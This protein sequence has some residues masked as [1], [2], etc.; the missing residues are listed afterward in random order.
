MIQET[1]GDKTLSGIGICADRSPREILSIEAGELWVQGG[2]YARVPLTR[3]VVLRW[4]NGALEL[5]P[6]AALLEG[7][8]SRRE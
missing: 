7:L 2:F 3:V 8:G 6:R 1:Y 4:R 5:L